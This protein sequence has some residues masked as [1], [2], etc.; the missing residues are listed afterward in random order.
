MG[1]IISLTYD[2]A[3]GSHLSVA[4]P[5]LERRGLK[6]TFFVADRHGT[7]SAKPEP[8]RKLR[9]AGHELAAHT[10]KHPCPQAGLWSPPGI[11]M[12]QFDEAMMETDLKANIALIRDLGE[13]R[14][15]LS[16]AYP[17]GCTWLGPDKR[18]Y[19]PMIKKYFCAARSCIEG[20][21]D[22]KRPDFYETRC[23]NAT[24]MNGR[25]LIAAAEKAAVG[26]HW[27][28]FMFHGVGGDYL[29][30]TR[31]DH[32]EFLDYLLSRTREF[33]VEPFGD[34]ALRLRAQ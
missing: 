13:T 8:W 33:V 29:S 1:A 24:G 16:F 9:Q 27:A 26:G 7:L 20:Y 22:P 3:T 31:E 21:E 19:I 5:S 6:G 15:E 23:I 32:D 28:V 18:S 10:L 12:D 11:E 2:D 34:A 17:C 30:V 14:T 25:Q 4:A